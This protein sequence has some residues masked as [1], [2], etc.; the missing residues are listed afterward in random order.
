MSG[1]QTSYEQLKKMAGGVV[2]TEGEKQ[3]MNYLYTTRKKIN[4]LPYIYQRLYQLES[5]KDI[6][7]FSG[8]ADELNRIEKY[9]QLWKSGNFGSIALVGE[10]GSGR[11]SLIN[12]AEISVLKQIKHYRIS[13]PKEV[14]TEAALAGIFAEV[15][16]VEKAGSLAELEE[17]LNNITTPVAIVVENMQNIFLRTIQGFDLIERLLL[18]VSRV[19]QKVFWVI[20]CGMHM[21]NYLDR[22]LSIKRY[23]YD[24]I[25]L[26]NVAAEVMKEI[27]L[28]RHRLSGFELEYQPSE[29][30]LN[31]RK[32]KKLAGEKER[33]DYLERQ[34]F[35]DLHSH[36]GGNISIALMLWQ[37]SVISIKPD[38]V[39]IQTGQFLDS[40]FLNSLAD[41]ELFTLEL[42]I[43]VE[44]LSIEEHAMIF[45]MGILQSELILLRLK[46]KGILYET[47]EGFQIHLLVYKQVIKVL[48]NRNMLK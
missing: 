39:F 5:L 1:A 14:K 15:L 33:Q 29:E 4:N 34:F 37:L 20:S 12:L 38:K 8:R 7:M 43:E 24:V 27:V 45:N 22:V 46:N 25:I 42:I 3:L 35:K 30:V 9:Y 11:T 2:I 23:F 31:D 19:P 13:M 16:P 48:G 44:S 32:Y 17:A 6:S 36:T 40:E 10:K 26:D 41:E 28:T 18:M 21:W 47:S